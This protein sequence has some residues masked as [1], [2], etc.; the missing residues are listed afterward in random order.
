M[1]LA[2]A[3]VRFFRRV[4]GRSNPRIE[5]L[6]RIVKM[7]GK[8]RENEIPCDEA[9]RLLDQYA[10]ALLRGEDA[11]KLFPQVAHHLELCMDCKEELEALLLALD[12]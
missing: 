2:R 3:I 10:E 9:Y 11:E 12:Q 4:L 7:I 8:T 6:K 1:K 5:R